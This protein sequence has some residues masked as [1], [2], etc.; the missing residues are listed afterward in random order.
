MRERERAIYQSSTSRKWISKFTKMSNHSCKI[1]TD[2]IR[3]PKTSYQNSPSSIWRCRS[4]RSEGSI[5]SHS[6]ELHK[7]R[8]VDR[9]KHSARDTHE[10]RRSLNKTRDGNLSATQRHLWCFGALTCHSRHRSTPPGP[11]GYG[12]GSGVPCCHGNQPT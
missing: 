3:A 9:S 10:S 1:P 11:T 4:S 7:T 5:S 6:E 8:Q 2:S 12:L